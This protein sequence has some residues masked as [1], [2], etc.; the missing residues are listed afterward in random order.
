MTLHYR[1]LLC[2]SVVVL[3]CIACSHTW[4]QARSFESALRCGLQVEAAIELADSFGA[5][6]ACR[7]IV[8]STV[9]FIEKGSTTFRLVFDSDGLFLVEHSETCGIYPPVSG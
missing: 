9:C 3:C 2:G 8:H 6:L 5:N 7:M 4:P 1:V